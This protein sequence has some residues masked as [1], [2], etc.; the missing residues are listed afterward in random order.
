M[1]KIFVSEWNSCYKTHDFAVS[2]P[3]KEWIHFNL[4]GSLMAF[5]IWL[6]KYDLWL[7]IRNNSQFQEPDKLYIFSS[8]DLLFLASPISWAVYCNWSCPTKDKAVYACM[9]VHSNFNSRNQRR[10]PQHLFCTSSKDI[11]AGQLY[12][13]NFEFEI[14][15]CELVTTIVYISFQ[16]PIGGKIQTNYV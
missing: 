15:N 8:I 14:P 7:E 11:E 6:L 2:L 3:A 13:Y 12:E 9:V 5:S 1:I 10:F 16:P 4:S